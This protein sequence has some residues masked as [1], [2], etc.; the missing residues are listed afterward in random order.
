[1]KKT[2]NNN[3]VKTCISV[4]VE[5]RTRSR[6]KKTQ[7]DILRNDLKVKGFNRE[8]AIDHVAWRIAI[9]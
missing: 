3:C 2:E 5:G 8:A 4:T 7:V 6:P 1:V 9:R